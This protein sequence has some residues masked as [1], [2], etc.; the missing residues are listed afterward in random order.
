ML[1][2]LVVTVFGSAAEKWYYLLLL[3]WG[4]IGSTSQKHERQPNVSWLQSCFN[5]V[6]RQRVCKHL[7]HRFSSTGCYCVCWPSA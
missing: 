3:G 6:M 5:L 7:I 4:N 2:M 1:Y